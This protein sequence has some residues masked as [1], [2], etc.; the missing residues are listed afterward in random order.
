MSTRVRSSAFLFGLLFA[1][2]LSATPA[3]AELNAYRGTRVYPGLG[4]P[5]GN[6]G[7]WGPFY[8]ASY[9][10]SGS[11]GYSHLQSGY[12]LPVAS[13]CGTYGC[14]TGYGASRMCY[15]GYCWTVPV[16]INF[17]TPPLKV[18]PPRSG[19]M[20]DNNYKLNDLRKDIDPPAPPANDEPAKED[21]V[22]PVKEEARQRLSSDQLIARL[23]G[24][25]SKESA[26]QLN[27]AKRA[28]QPVTSVAVAAG[29]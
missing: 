7:W 25:L 29:K 5:H 11:Y 19:L 12:A 15:G 26:R 28:V 27:T 13:G 21:A 22:P 14:G 9:R 6:G 16:L 23:A 18:E 1:A 10:H 20:N 17:D 4:T 24:V 2:V 3:S 8:R